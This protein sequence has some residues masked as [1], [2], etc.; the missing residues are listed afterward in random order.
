MITYLIQHITNFVDKIKEISYLQEKQSISENIITPKSVSKYFTG[1]DYIYTNDN[2]YVVFFFSNGRHNF[3][4]NTY[5]KVPIN[6]LQNIKNYKYVIIDDCP[7]S[8]TWVSVK[9][10]LYYYYALFSGGNAHNKDNTITNSK[11]YKF[12]LKMNVVN[13]YIYKTILPARYCLL[14]DLGLLNGKSKHGILN[15]IIVGSNGVSIFN[16]NEQDNLLLNIKPTNL[17]NRYLG[18]LPY[19]IIKPEYLIIGQRTDGC[20]LKRNTPNI[21]V[22]LKTMQLIESLTFCDLSTVSIS[23][24]SKKYNT[25]SSYKEHTF[26]YII[27]GNSQGETITIPDYTWKIIKNP[28]NKII[29]ITPYNLIKNMDNYA[30]QKDKKF[31]NNTATRSIFSFHLNDNPYPYKLIVCEGTQSFILIP[32][33]HTQQP[34]YDKVYKLNNTEFLRSRGGIAIINQN[35]IFVIFAIYDSDNIYF[36]IPKVELITNAIPL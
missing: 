7:G 30:E 23:L 18:V 1:V 22:N 10:D 24:I 9:K 31:I 16:Y 4:V 34:Y 2:K 19:P 33:K 35:N 12:N 11:L 25:S 13:T 29:N 36:K 15:C 26:D 6:D 21:V 14:C 3:G 17:D 5:I 32:K 20:K 27:T 28:E 8:Y